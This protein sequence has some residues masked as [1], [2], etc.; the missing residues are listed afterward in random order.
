MIVGTFIPGS[1]I[2]FAGGILVGLHALDFGWAAAAAVLGA[3]AGDGTSFWL[4]RH[5]RAAIR[6]TWPIRTH[7]AILERGEAY[8]ALHGGKSVFLGR[9]VAPVRAI[10][11]VVAGMANMSGRRFFA[12]NVLS[13]LAWA[14]AH[15]VPGTL[16]GASLE[17]AGAVSSRLVVLVAL[18]VG[19]SWAIAQL[20]GAVLRASLP[21]VRGLRVRLVARSSASSGPAA[22]V[23][24][25]LLDPNRREPLALLVSATLLVG[26]TWLFLGVV[27]DVVT[28][29]TLVDVDR[30]IYGALQ[31]LRTQWGDDV[32][33]V[34]SELGSAQVT[35]AVIAAVAL[36]FTLARRFRTLAY[37]VT[38]AVVAEFFVLALKSGME[39]ARPST[40]YALVDEFAFPSGHAA[41]ATVVYGFLAFLL[42]RGKPAW[43]Q[44]IYAGTATAIALLMAFSRLYL[45]AH[46]FS[47]VVASFGLGIAWIA[48]L[49]IAY[50]HHVRERKLAAPPVIAIVLA[51]LAF[52]GG[53]YA[54]RHHARDLAR[55][56]K[57]TTVPTIEF[58]AWRDGEWRTLPAA[59][60]EIGGER[61]EPFSVQWVATR[62]AIERALD[63]HGFRSPPRWRSSAALLW[64]VPSTPVGELP[65]L[66]KLEQGQPARLTFV[67]EDGARARVVVRL[68]PAADAVHASPPAEATPLWIGMV[69]AEHARTELG[70]IQTV[71]AVDA[72]ALAEAGLSSVAPHGM[73][74][75]RASGESVLLLW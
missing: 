23:L 45:G 29:D 38:A 20:I 50:L 49:A 66:P 70:L 75:R 35:I 21:I 64:L 2:V 16:F 36:W 22:R 17:L 71:R 33:V 39:R 5:Y 56:A 15:L 31:A 28:R 72:A 9:F 47:D 34:V 63:A 54:G 30:S 7:P 41:L 60:E 74:V 55:Y 24:L 13:A 69:T 27:E 8:V 18:L 68:W 61:N 4:G 12:M 46:W 65:V 58:A 48:L 62:E 67:R 32:A 73:P 10:V 3:I 52:V 59:R 42:G 1:S 53:S 11:P 51:T 37:F 6:R 14:A 25:S 44:M 57:A 43:L 19:G 40:P 26:G